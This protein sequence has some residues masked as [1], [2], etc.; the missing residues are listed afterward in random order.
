MALH[1]NEE[2]FCVKL[3]KTACKY[4]VDEDGERI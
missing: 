4:A 3:P 1:Y 2:P